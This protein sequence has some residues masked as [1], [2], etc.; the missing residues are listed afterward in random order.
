[1]IEQENQ[2]GERKGAGRQPNS[3]AVRRTLSLTYYY[4][5]SHTNS[6]CLT[7]HHTTPHTMQSLHT[8]TPTVCHRVPSSSAFHQFGKRKLISKR[9]VK[10][11]TCFAARDFPVQYEGLKIITYLTYHQHIIYLRTYKKCFIWGVF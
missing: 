8:P 2:G 9:S 11:Q 4:Y 7:P 10:L 6:D 1:M 3:W 5:N